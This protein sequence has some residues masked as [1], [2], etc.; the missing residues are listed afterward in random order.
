M[1]L[2]TDLA[3]PLGRPFRKGISGNPKGR[4]VGSR[5]KATLRLEALLDEAGEALFLKLI[6]RALEGDMIAMRLCL[7]VM[8]PPGRKRGFEI[9]LPALETVGQCIQA[10]AMVIEAVAR[11]DITLD[12][13]KG[14]SEL[15]D[16][17]RRGL[18]RAEEQ[19]RACPEFPQ[20]I[21]RD[22]T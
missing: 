19:A 20:N 1:T 4:P 8:F 6:D 22:G 9:T 7:K 16:L 15:V 12:E 11:G 10:Q 3:R 14:L 21:A 5:N 17:Q 2:T 13:A 18:A